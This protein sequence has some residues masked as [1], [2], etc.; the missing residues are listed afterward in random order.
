M[1][2][3][4]T[5]AL[6]AAAVGIGAYMVFVESK[7]DAPTDSHEVAIWS[8]TENQASD[9]KTL[10]VK[11]DGKE[12]TYTREGDTWRYAKEPKRELDSTTWDP[13]YTGIRT[14][15][16]TRKVEEKAADLAKYGLDKPTAEL[17][18]GDE[19]TPYH[20]T[21][22]EK[23][24]LADAYYVRSAKDG[25]VYTVAQWKVDEWKNLATKPP[26]APLPTPSPSPS[27]SP[28]AKA[29][30]TPAATPSATPSKK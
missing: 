20:V 10:V 16:A 17:R 4:F 7:K 3:K 26:L 8:L 25:T 13:A 15:M 14:M 19:K 27:P 24:P 9:L 29:S 11:A 12:A 23:S 18:W 21:V 1:K 28:S 6:V 22:G 5:W 2:N 30:A